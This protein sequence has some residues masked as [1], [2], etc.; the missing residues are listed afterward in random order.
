MATFTD[1]FRWF[2]RL[3]IQDSL[4]PFLLVFTIIFAILQKV[5]LFGEDRK[6]IHV[7]LA[8][9]IGLLFVIPHVTNTYPI[10]AD[11][12]EIINNAIPNVGVLII[13]II[14]VLL[15]VGVFGHKLNIKG[16]PLAM[17]VILLA[18][19]FVLYI[20]GQA[21]GWWHTSGFPSLF[22]WLGNPET[23]AM[24]IILAVFLIIVFFIIGGSREG[25]AR[26]SAGNLLDYFKSMF[27]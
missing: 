24:L 7:V 15:I 22:S 9:I 8:L 14:M 5:N 1:L 25:N 6:N 4:L 21:A 27:E 2:V 18:F 3:G 20:F 16:S 11:P 19:G 10:K 12:V 13:A 17:V 23:R 26:R